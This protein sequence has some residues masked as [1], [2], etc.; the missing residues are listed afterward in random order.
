MTAAAG[1]H[2]T[3]RR[4]AA[5]LLGVGGFY[6]ILNVFFAAKAD[7]FLT[8]PNAVNII[9]PSGAVLAGPLV[10]AEGILYAD[11]DLDDA[12]ARRRMVDPAGHYNRPDVFRL[13][14]DDRP[15]RTSSLWQ[16]PSRAGSSP[17]RPTIWPLRIRPPSGNHAPLIEATGRT[18]VFH[19][20]GDRYR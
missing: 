17:G 1:D 4:V 10:R 14:A 13:V 20:G 5:Q 16:A 12:R 9:G 18:V 11:L 15:K 3:R 19:R 7:N 6:V 2:G 8:A